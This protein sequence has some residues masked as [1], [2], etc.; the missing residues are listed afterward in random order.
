VVHRDIKPDNVILEKDGGLKL[1][2][3]GVALLP[4]FPELATGDIPG[5]PSYM[6]PELFAGNRG[7]ERT[8]VFALGVTL[9]EMFSGGCFPYGEVEAFTR[10]RFGSYQPLTRRR[11]DLPAWLDQVL[12]TATELDPDKRYGDT[13]ELAFDLEDGL[14]HG[15]QIEN[16]FVP[17]VERNPLRFWKIVS[18]ILGLALVASVLR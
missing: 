15:G 18:A 9:Y 3:L 16:R 17:F 14:A 8:D 7:S 1:L 13:M 12:A 4:G 5:T 10:P 2:D 11:P 6:A